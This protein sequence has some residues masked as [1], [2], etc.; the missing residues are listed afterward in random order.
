[1]SVVTTRAAAEVLGYT[2]GHVA[3][4][5]RT[6]QLDGTKLARD[7]LIDPISLDAYLKKYK[8]ARKRGPK[9][10][11]HAKESPPNANSQPILESRKTV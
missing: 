6:K 9:T 11:G 1:M 3:Y 2:Q 4:L 7:I 8:G 5:F 10:N